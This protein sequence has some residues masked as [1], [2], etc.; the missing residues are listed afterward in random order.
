LS[1]GVRK[2]AF[3][4]NRDNARL[5]AMAVRPVLAALILYPEKS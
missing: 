1:D 5:S 3:A 2:L 4:T